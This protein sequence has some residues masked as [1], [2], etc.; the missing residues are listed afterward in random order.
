MISFD[1]NVF[2]YV[3]YI[4]DSYAEIYPRNVEHFHILCTCLIINGI[5]QMWICWSININM[6]WKYMY[7]CKYVYNIVLFSFS[8]LAH[9]VISFIYYISKS[10]IIESELVL[11]FSLYTTQFRFIY[12]RRSICFYNIILF[13]KIPKKSCL[14]CVLLLNNI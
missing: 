11:Y 5:M 7:V 9:I 3:Y 12:L 14:K 2:I 8:Q 4:K 10:Y 1:L 6:D 13:N